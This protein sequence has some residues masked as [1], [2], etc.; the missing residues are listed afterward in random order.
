M[1]G[2]KGLAHGAVVFA[3]LVGAAYQQA[4]RRAC[5]VAFIN[6]AQ[7]FYRVCLVALRYKAAGARAA[8]VQVSCMSASDSA[9]PAGSRQSQP[10]AGPCDS[11][12]LVTGK[13]MP[14]VLPLRR[15][16]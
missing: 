11:P 13:S 14:R 12:K 7:D 15:Q 1:A 8:A 6:T 4:N 3:A 9:R 5:G 16:L 2:A 10:I